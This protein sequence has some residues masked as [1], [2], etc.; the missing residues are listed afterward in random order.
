MIA[1]DVDRL[2]VDQEKIQT[3]N[4]KLAGLSGE[5]VFYRA[6]RDPKFDVPE[7]ALISDALVFLA[8]GMDTTAH[9]LTLLTFHLLRNNRKEEKKLLEE[10]KKVLPHV[11]DETSSAKLMQLPYLAATIKE[12]LRHSMGVPNGMRRIVPEGGHNVGEVHIPAGTVIVHPNYVSH[13]NP[14][15]FSPDP[16]EFRPERWLE[17]DPQK[18][19]EMDRNSNPFLRGARACLGIN[20]AYS[21]LFMATAHLI[22]RFELSFVDAAEAEYNI[23][24]WT[25]ENLP[26]FAGCVLFSILLLYY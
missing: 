4:P 26:R 18:L 13:F 12:A 1:A 14:D 7:Y 15:V 9:T 23:T 8:A 11:D 16:H 21:E 25:D 17:A 22:R 3:S 10:I 19:R 6:M 20:L 5:S 2:R 24:H